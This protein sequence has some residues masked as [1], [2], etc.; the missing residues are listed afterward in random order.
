M[1]YIYRGITIID[2]D[3]ETKQCTFPDDEVGVTDKFRVAHI[4]H[5]HLL[6][7]D[8]MLLAEFHLKIYQHMAGHDDVDLTDVVVNI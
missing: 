3:E 2:Y 1:K 5:V 6:P 4:T 8:H 7:E